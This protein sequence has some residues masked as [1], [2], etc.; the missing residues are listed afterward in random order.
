MRE[1]IK[2]AQYYEAYLAQNMKRIARFQEQLKTLKPDNVAGRNACAAFIACLYRSRLCALYSSGASIHDI[3][4]LYPLF[5]EY[6]VQ[7]VIPA[8]GYFDVIDAISLGV[9]LDAKESLPEL[10]L[11]VR[12]TN[13]RNKLTDTLLHSMDDTWSIVESD[14]R[15][16]WF[17]EFLKCAESD[18]GDYL[19]RYL[20]KRWYRDH[21]DASW[22][23]C[24]KSSFDIYAGYWSFEVAAVAKLYGVHDSPELPYYPYDLVH[25]VCIHSE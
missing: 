17:L 19:K 6:L 25:H 4:E 23:D 24:H 10:K 1:I 16:A 5:L 15:C 9:L 8:E 14:D 21:R 11:I 3:E 20:T 12:Q 2:N 22:Y 13:M 18:R 7:G